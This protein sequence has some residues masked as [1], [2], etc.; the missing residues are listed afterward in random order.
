MKQE[1]KSKWLKAL[2]SGK[3][4]QGK[5]ALATVNRLGNVKYCCLGVLCDLYLK[6]KKEKWGSGLEE[7]LL[8]IGKETAL[9][10]SKV[11]KWAGLKDYNPR[12]KD[13]YTTLSGMNDS[14]YSFKQI[15]EEIDENF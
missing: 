9:L 3:Y 4:K 1:I 11:M 10:P 8:N 14:G 12:I 5:N 13:G 6:E 7:Q 2:R 15:A